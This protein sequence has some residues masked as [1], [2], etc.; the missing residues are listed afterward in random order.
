MPKYTW[1]KF[2]GL[3]VGVFFS[4][5]LI[6]GF[7]YLMTDGKVDFDSPVEGK[8][9]MQWLC[10]KVWS[11]FGSIIGAVAICNF[12]LGDKAYDQDPK[13]GEPSME[14]KILITIYLILV[15]LAM[16]RFW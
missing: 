14:F 2:I 11:I 3:I 8:I 9:N 15:V 5:L 13:T 7:F 1:L 16:I 4:F 12:F 6:Y 10:I